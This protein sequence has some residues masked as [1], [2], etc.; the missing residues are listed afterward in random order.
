M[1]EAVLFDMDGVLINT[2]DAVTRFWET[3]AQTYQIHL[4]PIDFERHIYGCTADHTLDILFPP[5]AEMQRQAIFDS[6][7][8][9]E[10]NQTYPAV[11]GALALLQTLQRHG[12]KCALVTSG[13]RQ[14]VAAV[15]RQLNLARL[16]MAYVTSDDVQRGKPQPDC[17]LLA[18]ERLGVPIARC[19][20]F[21]DS[22]S[23]VKAA[24]AAGATCIG[25]G[26]T[27][28][29]P[30]L[31]EAG[32]LAVIPDFTEV[33]V[34]PATNGPGNTVSL[35]LS[36]ERMLQLSKEGDSS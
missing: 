18:A 8:E 30:A 21:E 35:R 1:Y 7:I 23:G 14:K 27:V 6:L 5:L 2:H 29:A 4:S 28:P 17:Y 13:N 9:Y 12:V 16:F 22:L 33:T 32:A 25:L 34:I 11:S 19:L 3:L 10:A 26:S 24:L 15:S 31:L 20:V 36:A